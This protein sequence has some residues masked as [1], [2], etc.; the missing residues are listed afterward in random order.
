[1]DT[2]VVFLADVTRLW[3]QFG[4]FNDQQILGAGK[5]SEHPIR[6]Y[7]TDFRN[8]TF[9]GTGINSGILLMNLTRMRQDRFIDRLIPLVRKYKLVVD[10]LFPDQDLL[11]C[12]IV[13]N[14]S[15]LFRLPCNFNFLCS[16]C[17]GGDLCVDASLDGVSALHGFAD[18]YQ[19]EPCSVMFKAFRQVSFS[20]FSKAQLKT[21]L[22]RGL[23]NF[24]YP[25]NKNKEWTQFRQYTCE[26]LIPNILKNFEQI[27]F[28]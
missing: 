2:D 4:Q 20:T 24:F 16:F 11:N 26:F 18:T 9:M 19:F 25:K 10:F 28:E 3:N 27:N 17:N 1:M 12:Y 15:R 22:E 5:D 13:E 23:T 6:N 7:N 14:P 8:I 21:T